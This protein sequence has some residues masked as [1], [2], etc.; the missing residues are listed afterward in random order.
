MKIRRIWCFLAHWRGIR[1]SG[2]DW[3]C[4]CGEWWNRK[5]RCPLCKKFM[6]DFHF[7]GFFALTELCRRCYEDLQSE[8]D[9][10]EDG[11]GKVPGDMSREELI[12][13]WNKYLR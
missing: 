9:V 1:L 12:Y 6:K 8:E 4:W 11:M 2:H 5:W 3:K 7:W 10:M 13:Y